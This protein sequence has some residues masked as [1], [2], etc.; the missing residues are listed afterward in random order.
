[1]AVNDEAAFVGDRLCQRV[2]RVKLGY[3]SEAVCNVK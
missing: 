2:V 3:A 1:V